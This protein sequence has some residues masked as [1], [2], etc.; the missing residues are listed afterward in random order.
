MLVWR[1]VKAGHWIAV[2]EGESVE[3]VRWT[4]Q[5]AVAFLYRPAA[6]RPWTWTLTRAGQDRA[7][8]AARWQGEALTLRAA[9]TAVLFSI[10]SEGGVS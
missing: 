1:K 10:G 4:T 2:H 8:A 7:H 5:L 6:A 3:G 9:K